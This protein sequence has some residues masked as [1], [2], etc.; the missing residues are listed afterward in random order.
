M[1]T[2]QG[3]RNR[4]SDMGQCAWRKQL[5][6]LIFFFQER[7][8]LFQLLTEECVS[9]Q[10]EALPGALCPAKCQTAVCQENVSW[11]MYSLGQRLL[12]LS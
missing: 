11:Q 10:L 8:P 5:V 1:E 12:R 7:C 3:P 2:M 4:H 9:W 6:V